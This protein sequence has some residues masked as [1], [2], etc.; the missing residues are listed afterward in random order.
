MHFFH[1]L[2]PSIS[3]FFFFFFKFIII[4]IFFG[5]EGL[6][7]WKLL[8]SHIQSQILPCL[9]GAR[10]VLIRSYPLGYI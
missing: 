10:S 4:I 7:S 8:S 2:R 9:F 5:G 1:N 6:I 3:V